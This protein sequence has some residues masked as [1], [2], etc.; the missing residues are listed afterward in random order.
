MK[1]PFWFVVDTGFA[2]IVMTISVVTVLLLN[3]SVTVWLVFAASEIALSL[4]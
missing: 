2:P 1:T 4:L 3:V